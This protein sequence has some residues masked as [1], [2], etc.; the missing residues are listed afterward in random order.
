MT[1]RKRR[2]HQSARRR[3]CGGASH[4]VTAERSKSPA[5]K[6]ASAAASS[7]TRRATGP[8]TAMTRLSAWLP[9][10]PRVRC[11]PAPSHARN[12]RHRQPYPFMAFIAQIVHTIPKGRRTVYIRVF[13]TVPFNRNHVPAETPCPG[14][15][16]F[17]FNGVL[18]RSHERKR[19]RGALNL[20]GARNRLGQ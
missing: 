7:G 6:P 13:E 5:V 9:K 1:E 2:S 18:G 8:E 3:G 20:C 19:C 12:F 10:L 17:G 14:Q 4:P 11:K 16:P 15:V